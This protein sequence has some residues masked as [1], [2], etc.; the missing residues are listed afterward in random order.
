[1]KQHSSSSVVKKVRALFP[2]KGSRARTQGTQ[3]FDIIIAGGGIIGAAVGYGLARKGCRVAILDAPPIIDRASRSNMGLIW[4]QSKALGCPE[5]SRLGFLS[6]RLFPALGRELL[7]TSGIDIVY[8]PSGGIIPCL[9]EEDFNQRSNYIDGLMA[10]SGGDYPGIMISRGQLEKMLPKINF[11]GQVVGGC[12]CEGDGFVEPLKLLFA[13]RRGMVNLGGSFLNDSRV[14]SISRDAKGYV[15]KTAKKVFSCERLVLAGGMGN[16]QLAAH[17]DLK[18]P[19][20]PTRGQ[21]L[22]TERVG[23]L[24]PI[25]LL[26]IT[27]TPGGTVMVGFMHENVGMDTGLVPESLAKEANWAVSVWPG[28][29][30]L[31]VIRCWSSLRVMPLDGYPVYDTIPGHSNAFLINTHSAVTLAAA[32]AKTLPDFVLG[33]GLPPD[34]QIFGLSRFKNIEVKKA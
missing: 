34:Q 1:M 24:L 2:G 25:P 28:I 8:S 7:D 19:V 20:Q 27:R 6:S 13:L 31:R 10:Q 16:R 21:V 32:H 12:F 3:H 30:D 14:S 22:L 33:K 17:F 11:G 5:Y 4:S 23:D 15:L 26:G 29:A 18:V 9:G